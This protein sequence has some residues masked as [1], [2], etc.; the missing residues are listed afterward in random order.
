MPKG[1]KE[2]EAVPKESCSSMDREGSGN[3]SGRNLSSEALQ[4]VH[5][6]TGS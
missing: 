6:G 4:K 2:D 5:D 3:S 1:Q